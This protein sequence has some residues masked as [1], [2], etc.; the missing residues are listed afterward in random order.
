M[1][2]KLMKYEIKATARWFLPLYAAIILIAVIN[3]FLFADPLVVENPI[4]S[5]RGLMTSVSMLV[6][7]I[8]IIGVVFI[9]L[10]VCIIRFYKSLLG[11]EGYLM[12]TLPVQT[13][14]HI[15]SKLLIAMM[16]NF[17]SGLI[18]LLSVLI[19]I[20][21]LE[22]IEIRQAFAELELIFGSWGYFF[23][24]LL[25]TVTLASGILKI[26]AAIALGQLFNKH[27]LL[28]SF[29]MYI[30]LNTV[31]QF[32]LMLVMP[33]FA[34][35]MIKFDGNIESIVKPIN[36]TMILTTVI[37]VILA[38]G[39]YVLTDMLLKKKLNLE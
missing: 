29:G 7:I 37:T 25:I 36:Q 8:L 1:L 28:A 32:I 5:F 33:L 15:L 14:K 22:L 19:I 31:S 16:W 18:S 12:F 30:G 17:L 35:T 21:S 20:P 34:S 2:G 38:A 26:Y 11:D 24:P 13:W 4:F 6:Y 23:I 10:V 9:T 3:R 27:K 39:C